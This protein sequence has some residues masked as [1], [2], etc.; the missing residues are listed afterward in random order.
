MLK[1]KCGDEEINSSLNVDLSTLPSCRRTL[2][3]HV[4]RVNFQVAI[5][6]RAHIPNPDVPD[7]AEGWGNGDWCLQPLWIENEYEL[8]LPDSVVK[9]LLQ[10]QT[11]E[12]SKT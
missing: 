3:Q 1:E 2:K 8:V 4:R 6:K 7:A 10:E 5:W 12:D 11:E 9:D